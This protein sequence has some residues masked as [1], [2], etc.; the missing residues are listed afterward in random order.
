[1]KAPRILER[2]QDGRYERA[3]IHGLSK[4]LRPGDRVLDL[5]AGL[6]V[7]S[8]YAA[9]FAGVAAVTAV[10][11]NPHQ[12]AFLREVYTT[13]GVEV[14]LRH[15]LPDGRQDPPATV[16]FYARP[17]VIG[18]SVFEAEGG[19]KA[20]QVPVLPLQTLLEEVRPTVLSCDIEG[21]EHDL[22]L[23]QTLPG[24][25]AIVMELHPQVIGRDKVA[26]LLAHLKS[27]GFHDEGVSRAAKVAVLVR[28]GAL[29]RTWRQAKRALR[30]KSRK[31]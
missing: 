26:A 8:T 3:E 11:P 29:G 18:S 19:G 6:G 10:E 9:K 28:R 12:L 15:G 21:S 5:G 4:V 30:G 7:S 13:N 1:M 23:G 25:R 14:D 2:V 20:E 22:F 17:A 31:G 27:V 24:L 16:P